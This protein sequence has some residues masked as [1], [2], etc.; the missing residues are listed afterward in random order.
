MTWRYTLNQP[1][2]GWSET[3]LDD[4]GWKQGV[5]GFGTQGTPGA[6]IGTE[7]NTTNIWLR[8]EFILP[9]RPLKNPRLLLIYD[10]DPE[11]YLNGVLATKLSGWI[12]E[13][14]EADIDSAALATL[15]PGKNLMA[16]HA[17]QTYGGQTI[18]V[19]IGEEGEGTV[20]AIP[21]CRVCASCLIIPCA[22]R[23]SASVPT[24]LIT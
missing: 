3:G 17:S 14:D 11:V 13:Y 9:D 19:G 24:T 10:E 23:P 7:W 1:P 12:T 15:K 6:I 5:G 22:T 20:S 21:S 4:S 8:R 18:D 16:V 2:A